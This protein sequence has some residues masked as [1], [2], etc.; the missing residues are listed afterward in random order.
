[1]AKTFTDNLAGMVI[2]TVVVLA[3]VW[4]FMGSLDKTAANQSEMLCK[5]ALKSGNEEWS[6]RCV[7]Y[8]KTGNV[9]DIK[10]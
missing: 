9:N 10:E 5:S 4:A 6:I 3:I 8:Y 2:L 7:E 1:M